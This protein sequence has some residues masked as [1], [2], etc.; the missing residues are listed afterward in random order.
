[1]ERNVMDKY[2]VDSTD[3]VEKRA[4]E[5]V[6]TGRQE[7]KQDAREEAAKDDREKKSE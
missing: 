5:L 3:P 4:E 2:A 7:N 1:M 6:K